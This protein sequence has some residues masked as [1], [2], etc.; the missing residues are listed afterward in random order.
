[1]LLRSL[2]SLRLHIVA[3]LALLLTFTP[4]S[5]AQRR[6][7]TPA[8]RGA[9]PATGTR[10]PAAAKPKTAP[11]AAAP[12]N[13]ANRPAPL[14]LRYITA[15][16][17]LAVVVHPQPVLALPLIQALPVE[18]AQAV[19]QEQL[20]VDLSKLREVIVLL[21]IDAAGE[22]QP[23]VIA[24]FTA[25]VDQAAVEQHVRQLFAREG[26]EA[27]MAIVP[28]P[29]TV[30]VGRRRLLEKMFLAKGDAD[31]LLLQ[32]LRKIDAGAAAAAAAVVSPLRDELRH[33][34]ALLPPLPPAFDDVAGL[35]ALV[36][37][38]QLSINVG[39]K[40]ESS[41][42]FECR[43]EKSAAK[44]EALIENTIKF[45]SDMLD[46]QLAQI[47]AAPAIQQAPLLYARRMFRQTVDSVE[48]QRAGNRL[49]LHGRGEMGAAPAMAAVA[50][51]LMLPA[52][53]S[54]RQAAMRNQ[55]VNNLKMIGIAFHNY[56]DVW[57]QFPTST[58]DKDG[59]PLLSW[60]VHILPFIEQQALY[61]QFHLDEPWDSDHNK[62]LIA[63][64]P[65]T[66]RNPTFVDA[67]RTLYL[68]PIGPAAVFP[69]GKED[70]NA[71][72][73]AVVFRKDNAVVAWAQKVSMQNIS[74]GTSNTIMVVEAD[75]QEA[76]VWTQPDD[77]P[78]DP[79]KPMA[80][81]GGLQ[82]T[83]FNALYCDGS[84][85]F[86]KTTIAAETLRRLFNPR[87]GQPIPPDGN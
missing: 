27:P 77:L 82:K 39:E 60:R 32:R 17:A 73:Q 18:L 51:G 84:V 16:F 30:L 15:D 76:I 12:A 40:T 1:M 3:G 59:K 26:P 49:T 65:N 64:L 46:A 20:G 48:R 29:N 62:A 55:S 6:P 66:Y 45:A 4:P 25:P 9:R 52:V 78:I 14:D 57:G 87:D 31:S 33:A 74:D 28:E 43:D 85:H 21:S 36:D 7:A 71:V 61:Q 53:Q 11:K 44:L 56:H 54:A 67:E 63:R 68:A 81:L 5:H 2:R 41:F 86:L 80:G 70:G 19:A 58:Y 34:I 24:R 8:Q 38:A 13:T 35:P 75:P 83:G 37:F 23:A 47:L 50:A 79:E 42:V 10:Q 22:P 72:G 69:G